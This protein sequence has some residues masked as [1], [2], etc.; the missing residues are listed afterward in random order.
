MTGTVMLTYSR[1][2]ARAFARQRYAID[3]CARFV[4]IIREFLDLPPTPATSV[5]VAF[6]PPISL[7]FQGLINSSL[8]YAVD[9]IR[10]TPRSENKSCAE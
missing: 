10:A 7:L 2:L 3:C 8:V 1:A 4:A 9:K 5:L 6:A